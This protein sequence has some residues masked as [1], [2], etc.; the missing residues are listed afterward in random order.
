MQGM[1]IAP[2]PKEKSNLGL[3]VS[4]VITVVLLL[5]ALG[6]GI[7]AF[8]GMEDYK[9]NSDQKSAA[10]VVIAQQQT[11]TAKDKEFVEK[12]KNPLKEYKGPAA[13]GTINLKYPKTWGGFVTEA[14]G[15]SGIPVD[16]YFHPNFV[17][18]LQSGTDF[19]LR[20]KVVNKSYADQV[21]QFE[22]KVKQG[23]VKVSPYTLPKVSGAVGSR[24]EGEVNAGQQDILVL[25]PLRD[26]T[27]E[28]STESN[29]FRSDFDSIILANL[30]FVP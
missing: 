9:N 3:I 13:F 28:I 21:K 25:L 2:P 1:P 19:A 4:L 7:W 24:V 15:T 18:G 26:K 20:V 30:T 8:M 16:A 22:S 17:P 29:Q 23:K 27:I 11:S 5:G 10:A 12:E 14:S 6:F